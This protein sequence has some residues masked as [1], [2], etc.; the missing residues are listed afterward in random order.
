LREKKSDALK[1]VLTIGVLSFFADFT[2][3]GAR[4]VYGP[5]LALL[6][7]SAAIPFFSSFGRAIVALKTPRLLQGM[8]W[9]HNAA[10]A[11]EAYRCRCMR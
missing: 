8:S 3:E 5:F 10:A 7:A 2:Y 4:S 6:S 9:S 11:F 1:F